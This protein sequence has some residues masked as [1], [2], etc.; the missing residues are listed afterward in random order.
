MGAGWG[1]P[2]ELRRV[3]VRGQ[4][5]QRFDPLSEPGVLRFVQTDARCAGQGV[6]AA[7]ALPAGSCTARTLPAAAARATLPTAWPAITTCIPS[8]PHPSWLYL[9]A[10]N[11]AWSPTLHRAFPPRFRSGGGFA[12]RALLLSAARRGSPLQ[13]RALQA[14]LGEAAYPLSAW[15]PAVVEGRAAADALFAAFTDRKSFEV[16]GV[17]MKT[18]LSGMPSVPPDLA[19]ALGG[20]GISFGGGFG[21]GIFGAT[22]GGLGGGGSAGPG[23]GAG[24]GPRPAQA[25][26]QSQPAAQAQPK[27]CAA[28][29]ATGDLR[30][31]GDCRGV[32]YCG[33]ECQRAHWPQHKAECRRRRTERRTGGTA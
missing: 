2:A 7:A 15:R 23:A 1:W 11:P 13:G 32:R 31:C 6:W 5:A 20:L 12:A 4:L 26:Q 16:N 21:G 17:E 30:R 19:A 28:C 22:M 3:T 14:L 25:G 8:P 9:A 33:A 18:I 29:G 24:A 27:A 10:K